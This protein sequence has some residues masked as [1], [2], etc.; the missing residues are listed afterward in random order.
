MWKR[1]VQEACLAVQRLL[2][3]KLAALPDPLVV[4]L[5][6][7]D[8][9]TRFPGPWAQ[10]LRLAFKVACKEHDRAFAA[11]AGIEAFGRL[12]GSISTEGEPDEFFC[13]GRGKWCRGMSGLEQR[14]TLVHRDDGPAQLA[15]RSWAADAPF[16]TPT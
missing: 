2:P 7:Q 1:G 9:W 4:P 15:R 11:M 10:L 5:Q 6:W 3:S 8:F 12:V 14:R 13:H 16:V